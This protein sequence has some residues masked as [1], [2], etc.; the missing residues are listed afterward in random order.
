MDVDSSSYVRASHLPNDLLCSKKRKAA[1]SPPYTNR[2][3]F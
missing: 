2:Q 1:V 3:E